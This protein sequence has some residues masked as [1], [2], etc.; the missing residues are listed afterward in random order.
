MVNAIYAAIWLGALWKWGDWR[1]WQKYYPTIL[2]FIIGD[3]LY[4]YLL[5]DH[6]PMWRYN[7]P[8][9]DEKVGLTNTH[10]SLSIIIIKYPATA[11]IYLAN[12]PQGSLL[13]Q[14]FYFI[15]WVVIYFVNE[16][17]DVKLHFIKYFNGWNLA[18]SVLF[19]TIMFFIIKVHF[20]KPML[21]WLLSAGFIFFLWNVFD[22]PPAVFR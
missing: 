13:K 18:W 10:I 5:S 8:T 15:G 6:F 1:N 21:A 12:F 7:P 20:H 19:C 2:F 4:L 9:I 14:A 22:I 16:F 17:I 11:L 3:L